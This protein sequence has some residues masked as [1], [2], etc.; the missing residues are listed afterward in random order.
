MTFCLD[1]FKLA[2]L[3]G[4]LKP[5]SLSYDY[6]DEQKYEMFRKDIEWKDNKI[7]ET[8]QELRK[9]MSRK[10]FREVLLAQVCALDYATLQF[11][12][13]S[14]MLSEDLSDDWLAIVDFHKKHTRDHSLHQPL[15]AYITAQLLGFGDSAKAL[16]IPREKGNLLDFCVSVVLEEKAA[17]YILDYARKYGLPETLMQK[18]SI[19]AREFWKG[20]FYQTAVLSALFHDLGYPWQYVDRVGAALRRSVTTLHQS[21]SLVNKVIEEFMDRMVFLP[22]RNYQSEHDTE[23]VF[24]KDDLFRLIS[25]AL[26]TH[27]FPGAI[28]FLTLNDAIRKTTASSALAKMHVFAIEWAAMGIFMHDM[29]GAHTKHYPKLRV[30]F[31]QDPI[32]SLVSLADYLEEFNRPNVQFKTK[33]KESRMK[34]GYGCSSVEVD[35][36]AEGIM[37]VDMK[38]RNSTSKAIACKF[39]TEETENYFNPSS[40]YVDMAPLGIKNVIYS[41]I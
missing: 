11:P 23:S 16:S 10:Y 39:K 8:F 19:V 40:G 27:G 2:I 24:E 30:S 18:D 32:S 5:Y 31:K 3:N 15:T 7:A 29:E 13:Y 12:S 4:F 38:Y 9:R 20:L 25:V 6:V 41:Q 26:G 21:D 33:L 35:I 34:Y 17:S 37:H 22:L 14:F 28:A 1:D 36:D